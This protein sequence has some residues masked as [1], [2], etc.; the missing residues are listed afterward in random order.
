MSVKFVIIRRATCSTSTSIWALVFT[1]GNK[2]KQIG[3]KK[4]QARNYAAKHVAEHTSLVRDSGNT[5]KP[6]IHHKIHSNPSH[7]PNNPQPIYEQ[8]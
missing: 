2:W 6:T 7:N 3:N 8:K 4:E 1:K 5:T